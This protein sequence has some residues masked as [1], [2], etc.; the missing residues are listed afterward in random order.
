M[1]LS[2]A[3]VQALRGRAQA[4]AEGGERVL[5]PVEPALQRMR[6]PL[7]QIVGVLRRMIQQSPRIGQAAREPAQAVLQ[8]RALPLHAVEHAVVELRQTMREVGAHGHG[9]LRRR[10]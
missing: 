7:G 2:G 6:Q 1:Q 3:L 10:R 8:L 9:E 4:G 5:R